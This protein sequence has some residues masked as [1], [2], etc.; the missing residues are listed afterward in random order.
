MATQLD[1]SRLNLQDTLDMAV[2]VGKEAEERLA[3]LSSKA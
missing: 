3:H 2:L 1:V